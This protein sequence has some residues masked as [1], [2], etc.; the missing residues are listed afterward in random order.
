MEKNLKVNDEYKILLEKELKRIVQNIK[1]NYNPNKII[2]FGSLADGKPSRE[3]DIDLIVIKETKENPWKRIEK[4]DCFIDHSIPVE[5]L[6]YTPEEIEER[7][8]MNDFFVK[9]IL[10]KGKVL[11]ER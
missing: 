6:V 10:E 3:S 2:L 8:R 4:V 5:L 9:E 1:L 7:I 11:Y